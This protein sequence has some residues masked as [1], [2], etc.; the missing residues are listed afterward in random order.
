MKTIIGEK[1]EFIEKQE[2]CRILLAVESGSRAWGFPSENSDYDVRFIYVRPLQEYLKLQR[3]RNVIEI[4]D[5]GL[6]D[7]AGWDLDKTLRLVYKSN[8]TVMEW[9]SSPVVYRT[10]DETEKLKEA[11][12]QYFSVQKELRHYFQM[13]KNHYDQ[14]GDQDSIILKKIFYV[15]RPILACRWIIKKKE[16]AP[17]PLKELVEACL[18]EALKTETERLLNMKKSAQ[19][20]LVISRPEA[21]MHCMEQQLIQIPQ[22]IS[23]LAESEPLG[24]ETLD[25]LFLDMLRVTSSNSAS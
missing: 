25:S 6:L 23:L 1:L 24:W 15:L 14:Y 3:G 9:L 22:S 11:A 13:A 21:L 12:R 8:P 7:I 16:P 17:V 20:R 4:S 2:N 19:E 18:P 5:G 10:S